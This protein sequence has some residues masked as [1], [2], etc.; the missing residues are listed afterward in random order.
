LL[1]FD[2]RVDPYGSTCVVMLPF[3]ARAM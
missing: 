3:A 1:P 2:G